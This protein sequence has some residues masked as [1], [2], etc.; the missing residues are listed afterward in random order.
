M[1]KDTLTY[2]FKMKNPN[3]T[4]KK[5]LLD[6]ENQEIKIEKQFN[7]KETSTNSIIVEDPL[8]FTDEDISQ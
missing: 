3:F 6:E 5:V 2:S 1:D 4:T 8:V 7:A